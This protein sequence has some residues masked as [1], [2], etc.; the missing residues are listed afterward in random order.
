MSPNC[1]SLTL[2]LYQFSAAAVV[3]DIN[4]E[5]LSPRQMYTRLHVCREVAAVATGMQLA[6][7]GMCSYDACMQYISMQWLIKA[8]IMRNRC[9]PGHIQVTCID[10]GE[11]DDVLTD[12]L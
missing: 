10:I 4:A 12:L 8:S 6:G 7:S 2:A 1:S 11:V 3:S 9:M 5:R